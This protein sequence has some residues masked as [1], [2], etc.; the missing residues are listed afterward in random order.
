MAN[1]YITEQNSILRKTGN[2]L[3]LEKK[4]ETLLDV[5]CHKIDAV[6][7]FGNVQF[8]TQAVVELFDQG[9]EMAILSRNGRLKGQISSPFT[10]NIQLR[11]MQF[12]KYWN[13][14]FR[15]AFSKIILNGKIQNSMNFIRGFAYNHPEIDLNREIRDIEAQMKKIDGASSLDSL[16]GLEGI[17]AKHHFKAIGK[18]VLKEFSFEKRTKRPPED[19]VNALLSLSYTMIYN[20]ISSLLDGLGFDPFL[21]Y[22][23]HPD[24]GRASLAADLMEEFRVP[25][26]DHLILN[27]INNRVLKSEDFYET[28][29]NGIFLKR[30]SLKRFFARYEDYINQETDHPREKRKTSF[31]QAFRTQAETMA[32]AILGDGE[33]TP[34]ISG[35]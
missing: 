24:Y 6:L 28:Q 33:Y 11:L 2:R 19:P 29:G 20:E 1:L 3:L 10:K 25:V 31:R 9:I 14:A 5:Q 26:A 21:G 35:I 8:T 18:M 4:G 34:F 27:L 17:A 13:D 7:I 23:H 22:F 15:L 32:K 30:D 12:K 16:F